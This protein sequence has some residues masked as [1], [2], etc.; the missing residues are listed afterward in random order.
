MPEGMSAQEVG[1]EIAGHAKHTGGDMHERRD[2]LV[3]IAEAVL[4]S[5]VALMAA[6]SGYAAAK[7]STESRVSLAEASTAR[8][9]ANRANLDAIDLRNFDSSTFEAWFT[10]YAADNRQAMRLAEHR[11]RP[12][13][14]VAFEA[15]RATEPETNPDAPRG[16]TYMPQYKQPGLA[17]AKALDEKADDEFAAGATAGERSDK[18]VRITVFLASILFLVGIS[19]HIPVRGARYA[20]VGLGAVLLIVSVVQL[21][22]LPGPPT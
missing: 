4:L 1:S 7:W 2:R 3:S 16:P 22:Q 15:W 18:Y 9:E 6:W 21:T 20:L 13:F 17:K 12:A 10:A 8:T 14:Q 11:F 5:I 19:T